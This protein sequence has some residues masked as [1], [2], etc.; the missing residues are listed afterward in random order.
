MQSVI[1]IKCFM[2]KASLLCRALYAKC[3]LLHMQSVLIMYCFICRVPLLTSGF[4]RSART[5]TLTGRDGWPTDC[6]AGA[7]HGIT[8]SVRRRRRRRHRLRVV[9]P[10]VRPHA[11][12]P[13]RAGVI[14]LQRAFNQTEGS[15]TIPET[16]IKRQSRYKCKQ[17][18]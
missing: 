7:A 9:R 2:C 16:W 5:C 4:P 8:T 18:F 10:L 1:I 14:T 15:L 12:A 13:R 17:M 3:H 6:L 11:C